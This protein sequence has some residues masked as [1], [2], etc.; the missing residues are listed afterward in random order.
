MHLLCIYQVFASRSVLQPPYLIVCLTLQ[1]VFA[2]CGPRFGIHTHPGIRL[3]GI[4][5]HRPWHCR[6][7]RSWIWHLRGVRLFWLH[8]PCFPCFPYPPLLCSAQQHVLGGF[9]I[10]FIST[11]R[12]PYLDSRIGSIIPGPRSHLYLPPP[13]RSRKYPYRTVLALVCVIA[14]PPPGSQPRSGCQ[15]PDIFLI[16][17][18]TIMA[19]RWTSP[20]RRD[21]LLHWTPS[22][23]VTDIPHKLCGDHPPDFT[24]MYEMITDR[25]D[26]RRVRS[27]YRI[28]SASYLL[29]FPELFYYDSTTQL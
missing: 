28:N 2:S 16:H 9:S 3:I 20:R 22:S 11:Y 19:I 1:R 7:A 4:S 25:R 12:P 6:R 15:Y 27:A 5:S 29:S 26:T 8:Q 18:P 14:H 21:G 13:A 24:F 17:S 10:M 23:R